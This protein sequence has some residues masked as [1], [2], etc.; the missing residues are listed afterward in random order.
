MD[1]TIHEIDLRVKDNIDSDKS[2]M[3]ENK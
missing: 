3:L 2:I 1:R